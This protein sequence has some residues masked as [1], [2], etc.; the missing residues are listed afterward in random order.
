MSRPPQNPFAEGRQ[1]VKPA[2]SNP[3]SPKRQR[4]HSHDH[5][6]RRAPRRHDLITNRESLSSQRSRR[7]G[8]NPSVTW[9]SP[10]SWSGLAETLSVFLDSA[11]LIRK[12]QGARRER[13]KPLALSRPHASRA[14]G[15]E[16]ERHTPRPLPVPTLFLSPPLPSVQRGI[17]SFPAGRSLHRPHASRLDPTARTSPSGIGSWRP[18]P[19]GTE[20]RPRIPPPRG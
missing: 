10:L 15:S 5:T 17:R 19:R 8:G 16:E 18:R 14:V 9:G 1:Q 12:S 2:G 13:G 20:P 4:A 7:P 6:H 11:R 3:R